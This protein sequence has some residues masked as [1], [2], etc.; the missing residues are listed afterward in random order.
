[1]LKKYFRITENKDFQTI[2]KNGRFVQ[3]RYFLLKYG[4]NALKSSR[5]GFIVSVK[6]LKRAVD[7]N[8]IK[9]RFR[10]II[11]LNFND[12]KEGYDV[13]FIIRKQALDLKYAEL[14]K[15]ILDALNRA[16]LI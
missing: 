4:Q 13:V 16:K 6:T 10:E 1:M 11:R 8:L 12:I 2:L 7:R 14:Q 9:R 15:E 3:N 5:F